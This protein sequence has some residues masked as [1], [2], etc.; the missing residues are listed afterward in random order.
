MDSKD[1][2]SDLLGDIVQVV[3]SETLRGKFLV[4]KLYGKE[5]PYARLAFQLGIMGETWRGKVPLLET[6]GEPDDAMEEIMNHYDIDK[7]DV[8]LKATDEKTFEGAIKK[9]LEKRHP[10]LLAELNAHRDRKALVD[11]PDTTQE[12][13]NKGNE[14]YLDSVITRLRKEGRFGKRLD[15]NKFINSVLAWADNSTPEDIEAMLKDSAFM[16]KLDDMAS[17]LSISGFD[18]GDLAYLK[19]KLESKQ[20]EIPSGQETNEVFNQLQAL[21]DK[22]STKNSLSKWAQNKDIGQQFK[23]ILFDPSVKSPQR[24][25]VAKFGV[26]A[27]LEKWDKLEKKLK[28]DPN[29]RSALEYRVRL[30]KKCYRNVE[31]LLDRANVHH[32]IQQDIRETLFSNGAKG[33]AYQKLVKMAKGRQVV[34]AFGKEVFETIEALNP[35]GAEFAAIK[36]DTDLLKR[37]KVRSVR[38]VLGKKSSSNAKQWERVVKLLGRDVEIPPEEENQITRNKEQEGSKDQVN[39]PEYWAA[40]LSFEYSKGYYGRD[41]H[42]LLHTMYAAQKTGVDLKKI[43]KELKS[44]DIEAYNYVMLGDKNACRAVQKAVNEATLLTAIEVLIDSRESVTFKR[45]VESKEVS[46]LV[47][48][49]SPVDLLKEAFDFAGLKEAIC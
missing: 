37:L 27:D 34:V 3:G 22:Q 44:L 32:D 4:D 24:A 15:R 45:Q 41:S 33:T 39:K 10:H 40:K 11:N 5:S 20:E 14:K 36:A 18:K 26:V 6:T 2:E 17:A 28:E 13:R 48:V 30:F 35:K 29:D 25:V 9:E 42:K 1:L 7:I 21:A 16:T 38:N 19:A 31:G 12:N 43:T 47:K 8:I 23:D 46:D 49:M